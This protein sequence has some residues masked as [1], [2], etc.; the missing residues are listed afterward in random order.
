MK[1]PTKAAASPNNFETR[2]S[3][4]SFAGPVSSSPLVRKMAQDYQV[5]LA[6]VSGSGRFGRVTKFDLLNYLDENSQ[7]PSS[8]HEGSILPSRLLTEEKEDGE[9]LEGVLVKRE[10]MSKVRGL[11]AK[12]MVESVRISPHVTTTFEV[13]LDPVL[14]FKKANAENFVKEHG[15]KLTLTPVF[16]KACINALKINPYVNA[17]IDGTDIL[18]KEDINIACAVAT[19]QGLFVPVLKSYKTVL[20]QT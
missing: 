8:S 4:Q 12:H 9:Y 13:C 7:A 6:E 16:I 19:E 18:L 10:S 15:V 3:F 5:N 20:F 17:S 11:T 1:I 14:E 2:Q